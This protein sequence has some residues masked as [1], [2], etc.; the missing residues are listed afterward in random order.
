[1]PAPV[2]FA[3]GIWHLN[4]RVPRDLAAV[5]RGTV[6]TLPVVD[7]HVTVR[8]S[9]KVVLSLR[10][11]DG[12]EAKQR[13]RPAEAALGSHFAKM[14]A[15]KSRGLSSPQA[16]PPAS[17]IAP[18]QASTIPSLSHKMVVALSGE[19]YR[20]L[21]DKGEDSIGPDDFAEAQAIHE[22]QVASY[23]HGDPVEGE[24][25]LARKKAA[26]L[27]DLALPHG[28]A[29]LAWRQGGLD[30]G[31]LRV[32]REEA[33]EELFGR[34]A[35]R[36]A[37][38]HGLSLDPASRLALLRQI[39]TTRI[40]AT[41][42]LK[43]AAD[44]DFSPDTNLSRFPDYRGL[45]KVTVA[46]LFKSWRLHNADK[47][48]GSTIRRYTPT[49]NSLAAFLPGKDIR[50]IGEDDIWAWA[51][52][53]RDHDKIAV[54]T[55]NRNDLVA[56][57]SVFAFA[58]T[59]DGKRLLGA[60][61]VKCVKLD[62]PKMRK[63]RART[64]RKDEITTILTLARGV[65][66][67]RAYPRA[68][69]SRRWVPWMCAYLGCRVQEPCWLKKDSFWV[70]DGV[71][72]VEFPQTKDGNARV[73]PLHDALIAEGLVRYVQAAPDGWLFVEDKPR[74]KES[75]RTLQEQRASEISAWIQQRIGLEDGVDPSHGWRHTWITIASSLSVNIN[76]RHQNAINGHNKNKDASDG[77][78]EF[79]VAELKAA[80][81]RFPVFCLDER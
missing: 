20:D 53:R 79:P 38:K 57:S 34:E 61:P 25:S 70:E 71:W 80:L 55:I 58:V 7:E 64:F 46:D 3:N 19:A 5:L 6:V 37:A 66:I 42:R 50:K 49:L 73:V 18:A 65:T 74:E 63:L 32:T 60:N 52:H 8:I 45:Q 15:A 77:Y 23:M 9:G 22:E 28:P 40:L 41:A 39:G 30:F 26:F 12:A 4:I 81:D 67:S 76:K 59:R 36:I 16:G 14:R 13:F 43:R 54:R 10:T 48:A 51:E 56:A 72:V 47:V 27:A 44:G 68:S 21:V 11:R 75:I 35:D 31:S 24:G 62:E 29:L 33:L 2:R 78:C 69:A 17:G 1:M